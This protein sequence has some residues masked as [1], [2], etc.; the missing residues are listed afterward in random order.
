MS[1]AD[2]EA[3]KQ[4]W[5]AKYFD[6][7]ESAI[8]EW[9]ADVFGEEPETLFDDYTGEADVLNIKS[10]DDSYT[11]YLTPFP[12]NDPAFGIS[13]TELMEDKEI[14]RASSMM[15]EAVYTV[16]APVAKTMSS[17]VHLVEDVFPMFDEKEMCFKLVAMNAPYMKRMQLEKTFEEVEK[18]AARLAAVPESELSKETVQELESKLEAVRAETIAGINEITNDICKAAQDMCNERNAKFDEGS[19]LYV[20]LE[21]NKEDIDEELKHKRLPQFGLKYQDPDEE[22]Y[23]DRLKKEFNIND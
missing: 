4:K 19:K 22:D 10:G 8:K 2:A 21:K 9:I 15:Y 16:Y 17:M 3:E 14:Q 5:S 6:F 18:Q 12:P 1:K 11:L 13:K 23:I 20:C 7:S